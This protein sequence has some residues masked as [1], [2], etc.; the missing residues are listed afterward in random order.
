MCMSRRE[1][2]KKMASA[3]LYAGALG[4][5]F[6]SFMKKTYAQMLGIDPTEQNVFHLLMFGAPP[7]WLFDSPVKLKD[8]DSFIE[9]PMVIT[10]F[11]E[12]GNGV[13]ETSKF[14]G[15]NMPSLWNSMVPTSRGNR[16]MSDLL[17]NMLM[18]RGVTSGIDGHNINR[19]LMTRPSRSNDSI[20]GAMANNSQRP[21]P[22]LSVGREEPYFS[23]S[24]RSQSVIGL[25]S[26][27]LEDWLRSF[28]LPNSLTIGNSQIEN[29]VDQALKSLEQR[30]HR[31]NVKRRGLA[32]E[33]SSAR[34]LFK[35]QFGD[36][37][38][39]YDSL[40]QKY[41]VLINSVYQDSTFDIGEGV[42]KTFANNQSFFNLPSSGDDRRSFYEMQSLNVDNLI[43]AG[44]DIRGLY[45]SAG[46]TVGSNQIAES[47]AVAEF[48]FSQNLSQSV[49]TRLGS[50]TIFT[51]N[52]GTRTI[53]RNDAHNTG[54]V[55]TLLF[56]SK[57][58]QALSSCLMEFTDQMKTKNKFNNTSILLS[59][60]FARRARFDGSGS[61]HGWAGNNCSI[62]SG[63]IK[64]LQVV[65]N[66]Q[67]EASGRYQGSWGK[68]ASV[69]EIGNRPVSPGDI[70]STVA[71]MSGLKNPISNANSL[72]Y[73][74]NGVI[75]PISEAKCVA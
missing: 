33:R 11:D 40:F 44:N 56:F 5:F 10:K 59:S 35:R 21:I 13:Y 39:A 3:P 29:L 31:S 68:G 4:M 28:N 19:E 15:H 62:I 18:I 36:L 72:I 16:N 27:P 75:T 61:D 63:K 23:N 42:D 14:N 60:E 58:Y 9:N 12:N 73:L 52:T 46:T 24:G 66:I 57:Y 43:G 2:F 70:T 17:N 55:S 20:A 22:A 45:R 49:H 50:T 1:Y 30:V 69:S 37:R 41:N 26:N 65:G 53:F 25:T 32:S 74:N 7:R 47:F 8:S 54:K 64:K 6:N 71:A 34:S 51:N 38:E 67:S 48:V